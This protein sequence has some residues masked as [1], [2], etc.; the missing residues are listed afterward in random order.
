MTQMPGTPAVET[1]VRR[2][3]ARLERVVILVIALVGL[4]VAW[5]AQSVVADRAQHTVFATAREALALQ[6]ETLSGVLEK[7][8][9]L[10]P[11]LSHRNDIINVFADANAPGGMQAAHEMALEIAGYSGAMDV[12]F[13][14]PFGRVF[15]SARGIFDNSRLNEEALLEAARQGRLGRESLS[16]Q[17]HERAYVFASA[18]RRGNALIGV[19]AIYVRMD[20]IEQTW[21]LSANP[22]AVTGLDGSIFI[23]NR[24]AWQGRQLFGGVDALF[25][26]EGAGEG[27]TVSLAAGDGPSYLAAS[28]PLPLMGWTLHVLADRSAVVSAQLSAVLIT[29]LAALLA[30]SLAFFFVKRREA[31]ELRQLRADASAQ[32]LENLVRERTADLTEV[33]AALAHEVKERTE[34]EEQLRKTQAELIQAAK[35]AALGQMSATLSHEY[36]QP[37]AAIRTYADNAA[38]FLARGKAAAA[39][40]AVA[41][42]AGLVDRMSELSRTLLSF[43][44]KPGTTVEDVLIAPVIDEAL[45]LAGP[46][47]RKAGVTIRQEG[48]LPGVAVRG[49]HVRL[50]QVVVNLVNNAVDA[51]TGIGS[52]AAVDNPEIVVRLSRRR[53][54]IAL[55]VEDNGPGIPE[56]VH[57]RMFEPFYSTKGVG[58]GLGIGLSIVYNIVREFDGSVSVTERPGGGA[59]VTVLL[60]P[61]R[62]TALRKLAKAS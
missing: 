23:S 31:T 35:L 15:A 28:R 60:A 3:Y 29:V 7:Y 41:R 40:E 52:K 34:A 1:D 46:R 57:E 44:R 58:E 18:V 25:A 59:I 39:T 12:A 55:S 49:G 62:Q 33:N 43:A 14:G 17:E 9:L 24:P 32:R 16:P 47:A 2:R 22:I 20:Q 30:G 13:A 54:R 8:R 38:E 51:L 36:N 21:A 4:A 53:S 26:E 10:P 61:A 45:M 50:T 27:R 48:V 56:E 5:L 42:I 6:T 19:I 11:L 37:L